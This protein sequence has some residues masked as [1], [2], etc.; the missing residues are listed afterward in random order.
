MS[1]LLGK[2]IEEPEIDWL[3]F[4][5]MLSCTVLRTEPGSV[6]NE[7]C[8]GLLCSMPSELP[9]LLID[10]KLGGCGTCVPKI[11]RRRYSRL[12]LKVDMCGLDYSVEHHPADC[13]CQ[14]RLMNLAPWIRVAVEMSKA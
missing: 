3:P 7:I 14:E 5:S 10:S 13:G 9:H 8:R 11:V 1:D 12:P 4:V 6:L 2:L